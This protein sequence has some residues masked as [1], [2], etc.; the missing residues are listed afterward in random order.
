MKYHMRGRGNM[1]GHGNKYVCNEEVRE[2][3]SEISFKHGAE[4]GVDEEADWNRQLET[5]KDTAETKETTVCHSLS[6]FPLRCYVLHSS[7]KFE[8]TNITAQHT[9]TVNWT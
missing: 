5:S 4:E 8:F 6:A 3:R 9:A 7:Y 2:T 1:D